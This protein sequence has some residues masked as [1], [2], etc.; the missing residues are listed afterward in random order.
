MEIQTVIDPDKMKEMIPIIKSAWGMNTM[1]QL[2]KDMIAAMRFHG[3]LALIAIEDGNTVGMHFSFTGRRKGKVYLYSHMTG[4]LN[5]RKYSGIGFELKMRQ[6]EWAI[7]NGFDL[8]AW[9]YDPLMSLNANFNIHKIGAFARNYQKN[10][11]GEM[12]DSINYGIPSDRFVA[13][14]WVLDEKNEHKKPSIAVDP[15]NE[16]SGV[17]VDELPDIISFKIPEDFLFMKKNDKNSALKIRL[18]TRSIFEKLFSAGFTVIDF[19]RDSSSYIMSKDYE[20]TF[21]LHKNIFN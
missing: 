10:F 6:K 16:T 11:Y 21:N 2:V 4:V 5:D 9:T 7:E 12:E 17:R 15:M 18:S 14:W 3:G 8:I 13:E 19:Q 20:E 1:D